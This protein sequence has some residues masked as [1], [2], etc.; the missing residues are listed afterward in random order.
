MNKLDALIVAYGCMITIEDA[1]SALDSRE[2]LEQERLSELR[3]AKTI[4]VEMITI[5]SSVMPAL[6]A[7]SPPPNCKP[8]LRL[9]D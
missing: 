9:V 4:V 7:P 5:I 6:G 8:T 1:L 3:E 2:I